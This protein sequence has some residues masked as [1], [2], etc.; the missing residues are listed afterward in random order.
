M[1]KL[2]SSTAGGVGLGAL[3]LTLAAFLS[4]AASAQCSNS[5]PTPACGGQIGLEGAYQQECTDTPLTWISLAFPVTTGGANVDAITFTLNTNRAGGDLWIMG[6]TDPPSDCPEDCQAAPTSGSVDVPDLLALLG[7]WGGPPAAGTTCDLDASGTIAVPDLLQLLAAWGPCPPPTGCGQPDITNVLAQICC[8]A[9]GQPTGVAVTIHFDSIT[10]SAVNPTWVVFVGRTGQA[11][12]NVGGFF[13]GSDFPA[14]QVASDT[15]QPSIPNQA[16]ANL[17]GLPLEWVDLHNDGFGNPY[18]VDLLFTGQPSDNIDCLT[19]PA[20]TGACCQ[21]DIGP[22]CVDGVRGFECGVAPG[23]YQ[24]DGTD[25][26]DPPLFLCTCGD[27]AGDCVDPDGDGIPNGN[28]TP[29]CDDLTCCKTICTFDAFC[30]DFEWDD[31]CADAAEIPCSPPMPPLVLRDCHP[32]ATQSQPLNDSFLQANTSDVEFSFLVADSIDPNQLP[33]DTQITTVRWWGLSLHFDDDFPPGGVF[34]GTCPDNTDDEPTPFDIIFFADDGNPG[35][36]QHSQVPFA[37]R[38]VTPTVVDTAIDFGAGLA[39]IIEYTATL[40]PSVAN[41]GSI[42]WLA[43]QRHI[44]QSVVDPDTMD[45]DPCVWLW[46]D[47]ESGQFGGEARQDGAEPPD[48]PELD[49]DFAW[50]LTTIQ[51]PWDCQEFPSGAVDVPDLL[52]LLGAWGGPQTPGT[53]CD[54][55]GSGII[56]VPDLL[57]LLANWGACP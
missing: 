47:E 20:A 22:S 45:I 14:L 29:G 1:R 26:T 7:A 6:S 16:F 17:T 50:C 25:C 53:T 33:L 31:L 36:G 38:T 49:T 24:G 40:F 28:G 55:D 34:V 51:C 5:D 13:D 19:R 57:K 23:L 3:T 39:T 52:A 4:P 10:T 32:G 27:G 56:A 48:L 35:N 18:C 54:L 46:I 41:D 2:C 9:E 30:C 37:T 11:G 15:T 43:I 8:A 44:G 42:E 21:N 12:Q